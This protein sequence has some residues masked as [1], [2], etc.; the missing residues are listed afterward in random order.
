MTLDTN[1]TLQVGNQ[2]LKCNYSIHSY[3]NSSAYCIICPKCGTLYNFYNG[4]LD[5]TEEIVQLPSQ[6]FD[7]PLGAIAKI[8]EKQYQVI[9]CLN[10]LE[11]GSKYGWREYTL[12]NP[13]CGLAY[14]SEYDGHWIFLTEIAYVPVVIGRKL[15]YENV[16]CFLFSKYKVEVDT[17]LGEFP[18][19]FSHMEI[20]RN[21]EYVNG[22]VMIS[23][24]YTTNNITWFKGEYIEPGIIKSAFELKGVPE[25]KG[26]GVIQPFLG[27]FK[28]ESLKSVSFILL[29]IW[30]LAQIYF[31]IVAKEEL[32]FSDSFQISDSLNKKEIYSK[33]FMLNYGSAN[34]EIR[35]ETSIDNNWMY[36][37]ITLVN[38]QTGDLYD[39]DLEAEYYHGYEDGEV[40]SEGANWVSKVISQIPEGK[41]Y[42]IIYPQKPDN[43]QFVN[44]GISVKR[45][46][47]IFSNGFIVLL[48]IGLYPIF[49]F[50]RLENFEKK[51]WY[52][53]DYSPYN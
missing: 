32:V 40:W 50:L 48:L 13:V 52:T 46:V 14:L 10:K 47:F 18:F 15:Q 26:V 51:R 43:V 41:Y 1:A 21:E 27:N 37:Q 33:P 11:Y 20:P 5:K 22:A 34:V 44:L 31:D 24:E 17:G 8:K 25:R 3:L 4:T 42:L 30:A 9:A 16:E 12:F 49:Y 2:C 45:D 53:S 6:A 29:I 23:K 38:E 39:L 19:H 28:V 36:T 7:I 35:I